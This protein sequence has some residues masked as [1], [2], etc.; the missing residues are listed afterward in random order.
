MAQ[1]Y[2][3][4]R[5]GS[6]FSAEG[7]GDVRCP[8]CG[9]EDI[10]V[11]TDGNSNKKIIIAVLIFI[12]LAAAGIVGYTMLTKVDDSKQ[13][14]PPVPDPVVEFVEMDVN[15]PPI[16]NSDSTAYNFSVY[17]LLSEYIDEPIKYSIKLDDGSTMTSKD[18]AFQNVPASASTDY[19][20]RAFV[21]GRN[22]IDETSMKVDGFYP[23]I[24]NVDPVPPV[25]P[26]DPVAPRVTIQQ[27]QQWVNSLKTEGSS[28]MLVKTRGNNLVQQPVH[29]SFTNLKAGES[30]PHDAG[31]VL[32]KFDSEWSSLTVVSITTNPQNGMLTALT[33]KINYREE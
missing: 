26:V 12:I 4:N 18:G 14:I 8:Q 30:K 2:K 9:T 10:V 17:A 25:P 23:I 6:I 29:W 19:T 11:V 20:V 15:I 28:S 16:I 22:D 5:C 21:E 7:Q 3:C 1:K 31:A 27:V 32:E 24:P 33:C 13:P